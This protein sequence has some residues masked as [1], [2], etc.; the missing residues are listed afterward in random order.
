MTFRDSFEI[1]EQLPG[2]VAKIE[3][4]GVRSTPTLGSNLS[5]VLTECRNLYII[6]F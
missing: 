4:L 6:W 2:N 3:Q 1:E 5:Y